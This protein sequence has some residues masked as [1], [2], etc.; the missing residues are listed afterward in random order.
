MLKLARLFFKEIVLAVLAAAEGKAVAQVIDRLG[1]DGRL[2]D[3]CIIR[4]DCR[5]PA[6]IS[7]AHIAN[8]PHADWIFAY[9]AWCGILVNRLC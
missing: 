3:E 4:I 7:K 8:R 6:I 9:R 1:Q 5:K 2:I